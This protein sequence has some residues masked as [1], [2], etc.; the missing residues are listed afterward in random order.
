VDKLVKNTETLSFA[1][2]AELN[3]TG[4][5]KRRRSRYM[6]DILNWS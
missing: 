6:T 2:P 1:G 3:I 4:I 5:K